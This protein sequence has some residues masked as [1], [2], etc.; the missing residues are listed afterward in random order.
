[1]H[2]MMHSMG[3]WHEQARPDRDQYVAINWGNIKQGTSKTRGRQPT[4]HDLLLPS[5]PRPFFFFQ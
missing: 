5:G 4:A 3:F 2:E 1:M